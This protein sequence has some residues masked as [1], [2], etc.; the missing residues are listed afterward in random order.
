MKQISTLTQS[1]AERATRACRTKAAELNVAVT[2]A[3]VDA[4]GAVLSLVRMDGARSYTVDLATRKARTA[5]LIGIDTALLQKY[6]GSP[7]SAEL[8]AVPGGIP[9][10][11]ALAP[12]GAVG[13]SGAQPET[14]GL[15]AQAGIDAIH[16]FAGDA[17]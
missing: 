6:A 1:D 4:A 16:T 5:S 17:Q 13:I 12:A 3:V 10:I 11:D 15:I 2:I 7:L 9:L 8:L 14:D